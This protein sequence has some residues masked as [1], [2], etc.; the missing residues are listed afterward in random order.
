MFEALVY[1]HEV[2]RIIHADLKPANILVD[3]DKNI[4][5]CDFGLCQELGTNS[6]I[7]L[8]SIIGTFGYQAPEVLQQ[9]FVTTAIDIWSVGVIIH[10]MC[11]GR[12][13]TFVC[14]QL[15]QLNCANKSLN[16]LIGRCLQYQSERRITARDALLYLA[17]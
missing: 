2:M 13:P 6:I 12:K 7:K 9:G 15:Q 3:Q 17:D 11:H 5:I 16:S 4:Q 8:E 14:G 10:E 1:L